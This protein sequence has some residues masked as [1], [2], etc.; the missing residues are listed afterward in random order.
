ME[1]IKP[2]LVNSNLY[3]HLLQKGGDRL[4]A[5]YC[6]LKS[7]K[8]QKDRI[9]PIG[10]LTRYNLAR[11][12]TGLS[13]NTCKKYLDVLIELGVC[14]FSKDGS[15]YIMGNRKTQTK[16]K[17]AHWVPI[18]LGK[19]LC[20]TALNSYSVRIHAAENKQKQRINDK[21]SQVK[22]I[23]RVSYGSYISNDEYQRYK[24]ISGNEKIQEGL[25]N[26]CNKTV[27]SR[28]GFAKLKGCATNK[29]NGSYWKS[30]LMKAGI[31]KTRRQNKPIKKCTK[32]EYLLIKEIERNPRLNW[33]KGTMYEETVAEFT[34]TQF[35]TPLPKEKPTPIKAS[36]PL[37]HLQFDF[38][39][40]MESAGGE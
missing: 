25:K 18:H 1:S 40:W 20:D 34:T 16:Y 21:Q 38:I 12:A 11:K 17:S 19:R 37:P 3:P 33:Y 27:L 6:H 5:F 35:A 32:T 26:H 9:R 28:Q 24:Y 7:A 4:I 8:K 30:R 29:G 31:I 14:N 23:T 2:V 15:V 10:K 13:Y 22:L 39:H 36:K